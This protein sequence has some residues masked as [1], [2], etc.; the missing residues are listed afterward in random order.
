MGVLVAFW[1]PCWDEALSHEVKVQVRI[2]RAWTGSRA[3][4]KGDMHELL[5][6]N[7]RL[8]KLVSSSTHHIIHIP[9][10]L[11]CDTGQEA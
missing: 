10:A 4:K 6:C 2:V 3:A 5:H 8:D 9:F 11:Y 7:G 1:S